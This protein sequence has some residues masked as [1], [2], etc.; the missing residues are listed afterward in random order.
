M[1]PSSLLRT[2]RGVHRRL[3]EDQLPAKPRGFSSCFHLCGFLARV[4]PSRKRATEAAS[5]SRVFSGSNSSSASVFTR[6]CE[7]PSRKSNNPASFFRAQLTPKF[8]PRRFA[9]V[10]PQPIQF[11]FSPISAQPTPFGGLILAKISP[12]RAAQLKPINSAAHPQPIHSSLEAQEAGL[13]PSLSPE[14]FVGLQGF[15][16]RPECPQTP[17]KI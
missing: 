6:S 12:L 11:V 3:I 15:W 10:K 4:S 8:S 5:S 9:A 17:P 16:A 2:P 7:Q 14:I 13:S 1:R